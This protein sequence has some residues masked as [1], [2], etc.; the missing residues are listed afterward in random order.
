M[1]KLCHIFPEDVTDNCII[2]IKKNIKNVFIKYIIYIKYL[3]RSVFYNHSG[4]LKFLFLN[5]C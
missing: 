4:T 3:Q 1:D 2:Y 5:K